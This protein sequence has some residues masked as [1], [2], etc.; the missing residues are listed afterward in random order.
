MCIEEGEEFWDFTDDL[1]RRSD[2]I[3][4]CVKNV[5][6]CFEFVGGGGRVG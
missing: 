3:V 2:N 5:E 4:G 1:E 6:F